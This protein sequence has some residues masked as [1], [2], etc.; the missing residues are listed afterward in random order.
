MVVA[1]RV[2]AADPSAGA[3]ISNVVFMG[4]G[5]PL[6][7]YEAV[8][9]AVDIMCQPLGLHMSHNKVGRGARAKPPAGRRPAS[10]PAG[11]MSCCCVRPGKVQSGTCCCC[12]GSLDMHATATVGAAPAVTH[13]RCACR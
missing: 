10:T 8:S 6:H 5:E 4:M 3:S 7:N 2:L 12:S 1:C 9:A 11:A 13:T